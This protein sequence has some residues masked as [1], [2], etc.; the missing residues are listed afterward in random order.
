MAEYVRGTLWF[1]I[2]GQ[3]SDDEGGMAVMLVGD[4]DVRVIEL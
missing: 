3:S 2:G 4:W 1:L